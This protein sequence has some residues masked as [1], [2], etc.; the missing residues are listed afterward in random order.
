VTLEAKN[1]GDVLT[2]NEDWEFAIRAATAFDPATGN[3]VIRV[4]DAVDQ[5]WRDLV[6][7]PFE[8]APFAGQVVGGSMV[9]AFGPDNASRVML[10]APPAD[11]AAARADAS[12]GYTQLVRVDAATGRELEVLASHPACDVGGWLD[13]HVILDPRA[14]RVAAVEF[15][16]GEP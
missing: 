10:A 4:R 3:T 9:A 7:V 11:A 16:P 15:D 14:R 6:T 13:P 5:P 12:P 1:P 2:W 8:R